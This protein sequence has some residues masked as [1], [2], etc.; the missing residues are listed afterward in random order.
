[1]LPPFPLPLLPTLVKATLSWCGRPSWSTQWT[2]HATAQSPL[3]TPQVGGLAGG[4]EQWAAGSCGGHGGFGWSSGQ[5]AGK[6][7]LQCSGTRSQKLC[8]S[9]LPTPVIP[10]CNCAAAV[11]SLAAS[12]RA[13]GISAAGIIGSCNPADAGYQ[14]VF[15]AA[16]NGSWLGL[17][18][19][20][21]CVAVCWCCILQVELLLLTLQVGRLTVHCMA[22]TAWFAPPHHLQ[23]PA[24]ASLPTPAAS[25]TRRLMCCAGGARTAG[26]R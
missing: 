14:A 12:R 9:G 23:R 2:T 24:T 4:L 15:G 5:L 18:P 26:G 7:L 17:V 10:T 3:K 20:K 8:R 13:V 1:M 25:S 21:P 22:H 16:G 11:R 6:C 19:G